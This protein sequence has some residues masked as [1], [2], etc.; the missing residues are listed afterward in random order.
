MKAAGAKL[1]W[2]STT[3]IP[4]GK[5]TSTR[6][7]EDVPRYNQAARKVMEENQIEIDDLYGFA[8]PRLAELQI[9]EDVHFKP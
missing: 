7:Y 9:P 3:P 4:P 6:N 5:L 2:C 1:I 8:L